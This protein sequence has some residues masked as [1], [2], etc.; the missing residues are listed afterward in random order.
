MDTSPAKKRLGAGTSP[1]NFTTDRTSQKSTRYRHATEQRRERLVLFAG[2]AKCALPKSYH[3][4]DMVM[5]LAEKISSE[6][7][8][9]KADAPDESIAD[10]AVLRA[11]EACRSWLDGS[12]TQ[13][14]KRRESVLYSAHAGLLRFVAYRLEQ[15]S[16]DVGDSRFGR[17]PVR[18]ILP[19]L[20]NLKPDRADEDIRVDCPLRACQDTS[21]AEKGVRPDYK[22]I[23][24]MAESKWSVHE[25]NTAYDQVIRYTRQMYACQ[26]NRRF[27]WGVTMCRTLIRVVLLTNDYLISSEDMDNIDLAGRTAY[28]SFIVSLC[29]CTDY[30]LGYDP[31]VVWNADKKYWVIK[32]PDSTAAKDGEMRVVNYYALKP[33][34]EAERLFGR[35]TRG[36]AASLDPNLV[37][38]PDTFIKDSWPYESS[39]SQHTSRNE[40]DILRDIEELIGEDMMDE[41]GIIR[42]TNGGTVSF[43]KA[44]NLVNDDTS[45]ILEPIFA[46]FETALCETLSVPIISKGRASAEENLI[47]NILLRVHRRLALQPLGRPLHTLK[48]PYELII[49]LADVMVAY[50]TIL[51]TSGYLH[52]DISTN[53]I[54][55]VGDGKRIHGLLID[56]DYTVKTGEAR[57]AIAERTGTLPFMSISNLQNSKVQ[58][59]ELDDWES[60][61]YVVCWLGVHGVNQDEQVAYRQEI[62]AMC[63]DDEFYR[64]PLAKWE[65]GTFDD[66][67]VAKKNDLEDDKSFN[68]RVLQYFQEG[69]AYDELKD[70]ARSLRFALF[71]NPELSLLYSGVSAIRDIPDKPASRKGAKILGKSVKA[72]EK[73]V[74]TL[75]IG[76]QAFGKSAK[77]SRKGAKA[78]EIV[79]SRGSGSY[80]E[81][82]SIKYVNPF[83]KRLELD[84]RNQINDDILAL[85][86]Y[87]KDAAIAAL[88]KMPTSDF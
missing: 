12:L 18:F 13:S 67:A 58:R 34:F 26:P 79:T 39:D 23:L 38:E 21:T 50:S 63:S 45:N 11:A 8:L 3:E 5:E 49:V 64:P 24:L 65:A 14:R 31:T 84:A 54:M 15:L 30:E 47:R 33:I 29:Y 35:H 60:L 2:V 71:A 9:I 53:N 86:D 44:G 20:S 74:K 72:I 70:M 82:F 25:Q 62:D 19:F 75:K 85:M 52:R 55:V 37:D 66:V 6:L 32:C 16:K 27:A 59:S 22:D 80:S 77:T 36:F 83:E 41:L 10:N 73:G 56:F 4:R 81:R 69:A 51:K 7:D 88:H 61:L 68:D 28:I 78:S 17:L 87:F 1:A 76:A 43:N 48:S 42:A 40:L 46:D 57:L